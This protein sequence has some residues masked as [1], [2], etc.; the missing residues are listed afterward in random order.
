MISGGEGSRS[1]GTASAGLSALRDVLEAVDTMPFVKYLAS[2]G[3]QLL[4][5]V[6]EMQITNDMFRNLALRAKDVIVAVARSCD[7]LQPLAAHLESDLRQLTNTMNDILSFAA[8]KAS[9]GTLR[10]L[11]NKSEDAAS[12]KALD[13]QL[14]HAFHIFQI[15]SDVTTRRQ[16]EVMIQQLANLSVSPPPARSDPIIDRPLRVQEGIY[17]IRNAANGNVAEVEDFKPYGHVQAVHAFMVPFTT[18]P[19]QTQL[20]V[21]Q[22]HA[23]K[24]FD[25]VIRSLATGYALNVVHNHARDGA[26]VGGFPW[27]PGA[28]NEI[29]SFWG[30]RQEP[31]GDFCTIRSASLPTVLDGFCPR[32]S[33]ECRNLHAT[34]VKNAAPSASQEWQ[35]VPLASLPPGSSVSPALHRRRLLLQNVQTGTYATRI[36]TEDSED[37]NVVLT[38]SPS[39]ASSW[40]FLYIDNYRLDRF[41]ILS[42]A[43]DPYT[44]D[45]WGGSHINI[46]RY[47]PHNP[48]HKWT[49]TARDGAFIFRNNLTDDLLA[50]RAGTVDT[51]PL[52]ARNDPTCHWRLIDSTTREHVRVLYDSVLSLPP[53]ELAGPLSS[54]TPR[55]ATTALF[56]RT[57]NASPE[58]QLTY[59]N[60]FRREHETI[61]TMLLE[62]YK[63]IVYAPR[64]I[65]AWREGDI[66]KVEMVDDD[67]EFKW[68][69]E[70]FEPCS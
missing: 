27:E 39:S 37:P 20:W 2:V 42:G 10:K 24:D 60:S 9:R 53:P 5:Y 56:L 8:E 11:W 12:V 52:S 26:K 1:L 30:T 38:S 62:G 15:Q 59:S 7:G 55:A 51:L 31:S 6:I 43:A 63:A 64:T 13:L 40:S 3:V 22:R 14:T 28:G 19:S 61:R 44:L 21:V 23:H 4:Q 16:Q 48:N 58:M 49:A 57:G 46:S 70:D 34:R 35:L 69:W 18:R 32:D 66:K 29:W 65:M 41:A 47:M 45:H 25:F 54:E 50:A 36:E 17:L 68:S 67:A 33:S